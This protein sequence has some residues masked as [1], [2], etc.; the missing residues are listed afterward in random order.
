MSSG[1]N[2]KIQTLCQLPNLSVP[3]N[4]SVR[5]HELVGSSILTSERTRSDTNLDTYARTHYTYCLHLMRV[6]DTSQF[7]IILHNA[8]C[9]CR[10]RIRRSNLPH[11]YP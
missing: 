6:G 8:R 9:N 2:G 7:G 10:S 1:N 11:P 4:W 5:G 3:V